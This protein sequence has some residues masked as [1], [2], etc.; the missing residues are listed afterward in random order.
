MS[1]TECH[2]ELSVQSL[3]ELCDIIPL[4]LGLNTSAPCNKKI[5]VKLE[6]EDLWKRFNE[7]GTEMIITKTGR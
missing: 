6:N 2:P 3:P 1:N 7:L 5:S 4:F